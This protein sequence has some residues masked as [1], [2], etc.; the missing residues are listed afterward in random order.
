MAE[1]QIHEWRD[2]QDQPQR[3]GPDLQR[4][5]DFHAVDDQ[6]EDDDGG[7]RIT[8]PQR[9]AESEL[10]ALRHDGA[11]E[12]EEDERERREDDVGDHRA[13]IAEAAA[14]GDQVQIDVVP[15]RVVRERES[16]HHHHDGEDEDSPQRV[17]GPVGDAD[18]G[19]DREI[20]EVGDTAQRR[21][22]DHPGGPFAIAARREAQ[23]VVLQRLLGGRQP[24]KIRVAHLIAELLCHSAKLG[25]PCFGGMTVVFASRDGPLFR[26]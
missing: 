8:H 2:H 16:G 21:D 1:H 5:K 11:L 18:I 25:R 7:Q 22:A 6:G 23:R 20:G 3:G 14:A 24:V 17:G 10:K 13:V 9:D 15:R 12:G 26:R 19:A 4:G